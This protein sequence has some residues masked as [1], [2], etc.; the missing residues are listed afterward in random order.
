M[1]SRPVPGLLRG[2]DRA[3][4]AVALAVRLR[5]A[6]VPVDLTGIETFCRALA[7]GKAPD[8]MSLY[9]T[10]RVSFVR[11]KREI[12]AF[13]RVFAAVF[14]DAVL[15]MDPNARRGSEPAAADSED[16]YA[17]APSASSG[18]DSAGGLPWVTLPPAVDSADDTDSELVIAQRLPSSV[19]GLIDLPFEDLDAGQ[20]L[21]LEQWLG[22][23]LRRPATRRTR[24]MAVHRNGCRIDLRS[25][26][27]RARG[28]G[29]EPI[30][31]VQVRPVR[32]P[33][34]IVVL[35]DVSQSMQAQVPAYFH[36]MRVLV[37]LADAEVFAFS[38]RLTRLTPVLAQ[39]SAEVAIDR[40]TIAV[41]DRFGGTR[42]A[43]SIQGLLAGR[44]AATVRG[45][46]VLIG[47]DGWDSGN[48]DQLGAAMVRLRRRAHRVVWMNPRAG[49]AEFQPLVS[50]MAA[51]L[52][53]CDRLLPADNFA[54]LSQVIA[55]ISG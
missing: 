42:I 34:R 37:Q 54:A 32:K 25:T 6:G 39:R 46:I 12:A 10:A 29:W 35:C 21:V 15:A 3:S 7:I 49:A 18:A 45:A 23:A 24:R 14:D 41:V 31:L 43:E 5:E 2:V 9:W 38:T 53:F 13:D 36:L 52:P 51:A 55:E 16:R 27:A 8:R 48:P 28:T 17:S 19:A 30:E 47:S 33:R 20:L 11:R 50:T 22:Q 4:F 1:S 44:H 26:M 40:A